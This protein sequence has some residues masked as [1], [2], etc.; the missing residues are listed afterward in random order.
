MPCQVQN[1]YGAARTIHCCLVIRNK[2]RQKVCIFVC[3]KW[4]EGATRAVSQSPGNSSGMRSWAWDLPVEWGE[5]GGPCLSYKETFSV[6]IQGFGHPDHLD[7]VPE[8][9]ASS[10]PLNLGQGR[11]HPLAVLVQCFFGDWVGI[12]IQTLSLSQ[13]VCRFTVGAD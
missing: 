13:P 10:A 2:S 9:S 11:L 4:E 3:V 5:A 8:H 1:V 12:L 6:D 7:W